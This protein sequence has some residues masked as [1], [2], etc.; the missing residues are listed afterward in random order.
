MRWKNDRG[1]RVASIA[2]IKW[3][4]LLGRI[5]DTVL[6][7]RIGCSSVNVLK[8]RRK[9]GIKPCPRAWLDRIA[10]RTRAG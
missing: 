9:L 1:G 2:W 4:K 7:E 8:R 10:A 3:E 6:A 5:P